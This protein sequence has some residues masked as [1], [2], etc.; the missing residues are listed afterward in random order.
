MNATDTRFDYELRMV[1]M[2][3]NVLSNMASTLSKVFP[4]IVEK[5]TNIFA[6]TKELP[7]IKFGFS[8]EQKFVINNMH[9]VQYLDLADCKVIV[10]EHFSGNLIAY[11]TVLNTALT[12][13][14]KNSTAALRDFNVYLS[15]FLASKDAKSSTVDL[16]SEYYTF[17]KER[18]ATIAILSAFTK[19]HSESSVDLGKVISRK[20]DLRILFDESGALKRQ[21]ETI[22]VKELNEGVKRCVELI[23]MIVEQ[24]EKGNITNVTPETTKNLAY[25]AT[26]VAK[27]IEFFAVLYFRVMGFSVC[28]DN[29]GVVSNNFLKNI[30]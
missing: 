30:H 29:I 4:S 28:V 5:V 25:G 19:E 16:T 10:P 24:I 9:N 18:D 2:E 22:N 6:V 23:N 12:K 20:D 15:Q 8:A 1:A 11:G 21:M 27:E 3:A 26:E 14:R 7:E 13:H 17:H